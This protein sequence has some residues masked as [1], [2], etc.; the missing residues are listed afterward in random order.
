VHQNK[1]FSF[2]GNSS[3][4][5]TNGITPNSDKNRSLEEGE[6]SN[7]FEHPLSNI[8]S[9]NQDDEV[10]F[11]K[12]DTMTRAPN[13]RISDLLNKS[14]NEYC[15]DC[16][17]PYPRWVSIINQ[18]YT[19]SN[20]NSSNTNNISLGCFCCTECAGSHRKLGTHLVFVRSIDHD[21]FKE[22]EALALEN[23]GNE[24][25]NRL[26][27][28]LL[29]S[30]ALKPLSSS[31]GE[32]REQFVVAKYDKKQWYK[33]P[34]HFSSRSSLLS[35]RKFDPTDKPAFLK[36]I[37]L[38][39]NTSVLY[40]DNNAPQEE[41]I[42]RKINSQNNNHDANEI[43]STSSNPKSVFD[44]SAPFDQNMQQDYESFV[45]QGDETASESAENVENCQED[46]NVSEASEDS[47]MWHVSDNN[48]LSEIVSL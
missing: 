48:R 15:V 28:A 24:K 1:I 21:S 41:G 5:N 33:I 45:C 6:S 36:S 3:D 11:T 17:S 19:D 46:G 9:Q 8:I 31:S 7:M 2:N 13:E 16:R 23:G 12:C 27:E 43:V 35:E 44:A 20:R 18:N 22:H 32:E 39:R 26:Y 40:D 10:F 37:E 42:V 38:V 47:D 29:T 14:E 34:S 4:R 25:V 30:D